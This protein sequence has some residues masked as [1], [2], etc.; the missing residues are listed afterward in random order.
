MPCQ[1]FYTFYKLYQYKSPQPSSKH[2]GVSAPNFY[3]VNKDLESIQLSLPLGG[4]GLPEL[5][6]YYTA[7]HITRLVDWNI[8]APDKDWVGLEASFTSL[9]LKSLP[10]IQGSHSHSE[11][12]I[13]PLIKPILQCFCKICKH[14]SISSIPGPMTLIKQNP[15]FP[16]GLNKCFFQQFWSQEQVLAHHFYD[17]GK[18]YSASQLATITEKNPIPAWTFLLISPKIIRK[19]IR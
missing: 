11:I 12:G 6:N 4:I 8:H 17:Q 5:L 15:D 7:V 13:H 14:S 9:P 2:T 19:K 1:E 16:P 18:L 10:W 3:G